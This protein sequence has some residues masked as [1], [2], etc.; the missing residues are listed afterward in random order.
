MDLERLERLLDA[1]G[2]SPE[3]W[4]VEE[5]QAALA[6]LD[7]SAEARARRDLAA[8]LDALL[9]AAPAPE[10]SRDLVARIL[11]AAP[12]VPTR[13]GGDAAGLRRAR[14]WP[15]VAAAAPLAAAAALAL[16]IRYAPEPSPG[17]VSEEAIAR[18]GV[19]EAPTDVLLAAPSGEALYGAPQLGCAG[20]TLGCPRLEVPEGRESTLDRAGVTA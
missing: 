4:P 20:S 7:R 17:V 11:A 14:L 19:Y 9:D 8:Q 16:W 15:Y 3:R 5:R 18:L 1:Y 12:G 6:L 2:A 10:P 13:I